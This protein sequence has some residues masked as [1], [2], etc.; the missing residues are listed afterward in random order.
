MMWKFFRE[1]H[2]CS[3]LGKSLW[4]LETKAKRPSLPLT[5]VEITGMECEH[6]FHGRLS[7][8]FESPVMIHGGKFVILQ[9]LF[10]KCPVVDTGE[11]NLYSFI[12]FSHCHFAYHWCMKPRKQNHC[13]KHVLFGFKQV[14]IPETPCVISCPSYYW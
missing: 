7:M 9:C 3:R 13:Q 5:L 1:F 12:G 11:E 14:M 8:T 10:M 4:Q 6:L 2:D